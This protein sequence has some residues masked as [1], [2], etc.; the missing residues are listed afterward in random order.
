MRHKLLV[1][2]IAIASA[3][4]NGSAI[5]APRLISESRFCSS[6]S[7]DMAPN[8]QALKASYCTRQIEVEAQLTTAVL[9]LYG[10]L[11]ADEYT[12]FSRRAVDAMINARQSIET[13]VRN[14]ELAEVNRQSQP[15]SSG[16]RIY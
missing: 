13:T 14:A 6:Y 8:I 16:Y 11:P 10:R 3:L 7:S 4:T 5:A 9:R 12:E 15:T 2:C 1:A